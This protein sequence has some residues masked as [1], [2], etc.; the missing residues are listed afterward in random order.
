MNP[1][2]DDTDRAERIPLVVPAWDRRVDI[3]W[4]RQ[5]DITWSG[6]RELTAFRVSLAQYHRETKHTPTRDDLANPLLQLPDRVRYMICKYLVPDR[7]NQMPIKLN[8]GMRLYEPVWPAVYFDN[9][10]DVLRSVHDYTSVCWAMRAD[11]LVT[12]MNTRRFHVVLSPYSGPLLDPL[13]HYWFGRYAGYIQH[14]TIELDFTKLGFG[15]DPAAAN[16]KP[17]VIKLTPRMEEYVLAQKKRG[18][19]QLLLLHAAGSFDEA[20]RKAAS[21][22]GGGVGLSTVH[23]LT[24]AARRYCGERPAEAGRGEPSHLLDSLEHSGQALTQ[25]VQIPRS[26]ART[27]TSRCSAR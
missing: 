14:L 27:S 4:S 18:I 13:A 11:I 10:A 12:I 17:L 8:N 22:Q 20:E 19:Q 6:A 5:G 23:S 2:V 16:L 7:P 15:A 25:P 1:S 26:I 21:R 3:S 9:L 24:V